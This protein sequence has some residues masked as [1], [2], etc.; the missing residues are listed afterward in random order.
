M[1]L[2]IYAIMLICI[3]T[4][5]HLHIYINMLLKPKDNGH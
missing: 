5:M 3:Y 2:C 4:F 1:H